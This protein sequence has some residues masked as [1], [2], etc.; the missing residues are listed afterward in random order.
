[1]DDL[2]P[3][4]GA[5]ARVRD[6]IAARGGLLQPSTPPRAVR[7]APMI[8]GQY[9]LAG[10]ISHRAMS[11][12][13]AAR[14]VLL[15]RSAMIKVLSPELS[16]QR[17]IVQR[18]FN[19]A[20][21]TTA[22]RHPGIVQ[23]YD[24]G[25]TADGTAFIAMQQLEGETL[26]QRSTRGP[27][28]WRTVLALAR[29][30]ASALSA[31]HARGI[32][33]R[34]L[35]PGNV[36]LASDPEVPGGERIKLLGFGIAK[37]T[38]DLS[39]AANLTQSGTILGTPTYMAPEQCR[40]ASVDHRAD[41]YALGCIM[42]ELITGRSPFVGETAGDVHAAHIHAPVPAVA[43][44]H[45]EVPRAVEQLVQQLL[46]K[47]PDQRVQT[48][49]Q[50]IVAIDALTGRVTDPPPVA[51]WRPHATPPSNTTLSG[52]ARANDPTRAT[53]ARRLGRAATVLA[54]AIAVVIVI[55][56]RRPTGDAP[57]TGAQPGRSTTEPA[58]SPPPMPPSPG[59]AV[60]P[61]P[62]AGDSPTE[63]LAPAAAPPGPPPTV[64]PPDPSESL[65][66]PPRAPRP[67]SIDLT[68]DSDP[69]GAQVVVADR[70]LG[71]TPLH[72]TLPRHAGEL[73]IVLR[74]PGYLTHTMA[75]RADRDATRRVTLVAIPPR[76]PL[77]PR[78]MS[79]NP[80]EP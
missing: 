56:I 14:H 71:A 62:R 15:G 72:R 78:D 76:A 21:A 32:V 41:L 31:A 28:G 16:Q 68:I 42:F 73:I 52:A 66:T 79:V 35:T 65:R 53:P 60:A 75:I 7:E 39:S 20:R 10:V 55:A 13:Y 26:A 70:V 18:F 2:D 49:D 61:P 74:L 36:F 44:P 54:A 63:Q 22:I 51:T 3:P 58:A 19:E 46:A 1:M 8:I 50:L 24:F 77:S 6:A 67:R 45:I 17:D 38:G 11:T 33:H 12:V 30:I 4:D 59:E 34:D 57:A 80:F 43:T 64:S 27:Q 37:L 47:S 29:Q 5:Q 9:R 25:W 48:A 69:P 23:L 40:G